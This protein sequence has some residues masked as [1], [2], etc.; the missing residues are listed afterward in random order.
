[1]VI[2]FFGRLARDHCGDS[3]VNMALLAPI[4]AL[5]LLSI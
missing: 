3:V 5:A 4:A 2:A 1:M